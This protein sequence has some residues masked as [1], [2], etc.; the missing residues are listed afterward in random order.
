MVH[1]HDDAFDL[2]AVSLAEIVRSG[3]AFAGAR[4]DQQVVQIVGDVPSQVSGWLSSTLALVQFS[5]RHT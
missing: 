1:R 4:D 5:D 2:A 3:Q